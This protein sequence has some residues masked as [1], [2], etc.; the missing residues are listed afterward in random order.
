MPC[1]R[2]PRLHLGEPGQE[3]GKEQ[4]GSSGAAHRRRGVEKGPEPWL[5]YLEFDKGV[6]RDL[7]YLRSEVDLFSLVPKPEVVF[8]NDMTTPT[9]WDRAG[10]QL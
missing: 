6:L 1:A 9:P 3:D 4:V 8:L 2:G 5:L 10:L 7:L